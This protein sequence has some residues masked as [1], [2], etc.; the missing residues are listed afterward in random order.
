M[1]AFLNVSTEGASVISTNSKRGIIA[2][3]TV[4]EVTFTDKNTKKK[5]KRQ[6]V[7][8]I[9]LKGASWFNEDFEKVLLAEL[10]KE[11]ISLGKSGA[12]KL[13]NAIAKQLKQTEAY[14]KILD[15]WGVTLL[16]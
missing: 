3:K 12:S 2:V 15:K 5:F 16:R 4:M 8:Y 10:K 7:V 6:V 11:G 13:A 14:T 1:A 9:P